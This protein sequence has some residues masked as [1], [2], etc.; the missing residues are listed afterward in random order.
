MNS[1]G[2]EIP[3][4]AAVT[5]AEMRRVF[6]GLMLVMA[7][8]GLDQ[9][10]VSTALPQIVS[11][12]GKVTQ[13]SWV[14]TAYV[15]GSTATTPLYGKLSD[16]YG[17]KAMVYTAVAIFLAGS[18]LSGLSRSMTELIVF[19][20]IQ[21][22]GAGGLMPL[23]QIMVGDLLSPRERG[24]YQGLIGSVFAVCS[25]G[26]PLVGGVLTDLLSWHWIFF[27]NLPI[28]AVALVLVARGFRRP[29]HNVRRQIDYAGATLLTIGTTTLLL[30]MSMGG[31][32]FAWSSTEILALGLVT[33]ITIPALLLQERRAREPILPLHLFRIR[34]FTIATLAVALA[35]MALTGA[36]VFLPL[37]FQLVLGIAASHSGLLVGPLMGGLVA[38]SVYCGRRVS[39]TGRYKR[40]PLIGFATGTIAYLGLSIAAWNGAS[41]WVVEPLMITL[42]LG[43]GLI[44]P[45]MTV[46]VQNAVDYEYL[47]AATSASA[48]F[49]QLGAVIGVALS[50]ALMAAGL[51]AGAAPGSDMAAIIEQG[52]QQLAGL[53]PAT[54]AAVLV[55]YQHAIAMS[56]MMGAFVAALGFILT[57]FLP[58]LPLR[59]TRGPASGPART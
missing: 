25:I 1:A 17:R 2:Q 10:I 20:T 40:F 19:R 23:A 38:S 55:V 59:T 35:L 36:G 28:G 4:E 26:G 46:A 3:A 21:G 5:P 39:K 22:L 13:L 31:T 9:S 24:R 43:F 12:L 16:Q 29:H 11:D 34:T 27:V 54:R 44:M 45:N 51:H 37:F 14:V 6:S 15:L 48:F 42:G 57:I 30:M 52:I 32:H 49:R 41:V 56:L 8:A 47:G 53:E 18:V 50:G 58:E 7:L 33:I